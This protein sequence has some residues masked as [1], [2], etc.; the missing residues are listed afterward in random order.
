MDLSSCPVF[1]ATDSLA[2]FISLAKD[3]APLDGALPN[4]VVGLVVQAT[5]QGVHIDVALPGF[6]VATDGGGFAIQELLERLDAG[7]TETFVGGPLRAY[8]QMVMFTPAS[9]PLAKHPGWSVSSDETGYDLRLALLFPEGMI[10]ADTIHDNG[11]EIDDP[12]LFSGWAIV[13]PKAA[14]AHDR[15]AQAQPVAALRRKAAIWARTHI[16]PDEDA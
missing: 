1:Q 15:L 4:D 2:E 16:R 14:S 6:L 7:M 11:L 8:A 12:D 5:L 13:V 3:L 10:L 9:G